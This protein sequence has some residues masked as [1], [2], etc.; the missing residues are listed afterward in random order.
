M[1]HAQRFLSLSILGILALAFAPLAAAEEVDISDADVDAIITDAESEAETLHSDHR[2]ARFDGL[3]RV[4]CVARVRLHELAEKHCKDA[5]EPRECMQ[6]IRKHI[7]KRVRHWIANH[8]KQAGD[9]D[10]HICHRKPGRHHGA[11]QDI[12]E[13]ARDALRACH[14]EHGDDREAKKECAMEVFEEYDIE[15]PKN[16]GRGRKIGHRFR[17]QVEE[18]CGEHEDTEEWR[19]CARDAQKEAFSQFREEHPRAAHGLIR[20]HRFSQLT[21]EEKSDL[22]EC[23]DADSREEM[24]ACIQEILSA[25]EE[26]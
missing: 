15:P 3:R 2:C 19:E 10:R 6:R 5:D 25:A 14:E 16:R 26:N 11:A 23:R 9:T 4:L 12:P 21:D 7:H 1:T 8:C 24:R 18:T 20:R 17:M 13:E 22:R